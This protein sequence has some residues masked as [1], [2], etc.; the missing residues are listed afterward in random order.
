M[1]SGGCCCPC[2]CSVVQLGLGGSLLLVSRSAC[3]ASLCSS[4]GG[5]LVVVPEQ[6][7]ACLLSHPT[8]SGAGSCSAC[9]TFFTCRQHRPGAARFRCCCSSTIVRTFADTSL[10][11]TQRGRLGGLT[12]AILK[13][14][15]SCLHHIR[16]FGDRGRH[17]RLVGVHII[18]KDDSGGIGLVVVGSPHQGVLHHQIFELG[19]TCV[20]SLLCVAF[21]GARGLLLILCFNRK[22]TR[23]TARVCCCCS[24]LCSN[25]RSCHKQLR[26]TRGGLLGENGAGKIDR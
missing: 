6:P 10:A 25:S 15:R 1:C 8:H 11:I 3:R 20:C 18:L 12:C 23:D 5:L 16:G 22:F 14:E 13:L 17:A 9:S 24:V 2:P 4:V 21:L 7:R 19:D 26:I